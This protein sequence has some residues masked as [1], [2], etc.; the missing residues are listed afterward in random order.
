MLVKKIKFILIILIL[1]Q[2]PLYSKSVSFKDFNSKNLSNYFS[3]IVAFQNKDNSIALD[4]FNSSKILLTRHDPYL[5]RYVSTLVQEG[6]VSQAVNV[7]KQNLGK[8]NTNFFDAYLL[9][10]LDS[11]KK[12]NFDQANIYLSS[13]F[14]FSR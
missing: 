14:E 6:K 11:L 7:I 3:G 1:Y 5:K 4:F 8:K 10:I 2:T 9:L 13:A 12:E